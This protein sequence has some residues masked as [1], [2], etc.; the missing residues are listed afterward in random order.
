MSMNY[1]AIEDDGLV[2]SL[3]EDLDID[4]FVDYVKE[5]EGINLK[6]DLDDEDKDSLVN[7]IEEFLM[8]QIQY[9][10]TE[11]SFG[12][13]EIC[14]KRSYG[15]VVSACFDPIFAD[16]IDVDECSDD[17]IIMRLPRQASLFSAAYK[18][19]D[20]LIEEMKA[21]YGKFLK[22]DFDYRGRLAHLVGVEIG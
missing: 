22:K 18:D 14:C 11:L 16:Y 6:E 17:W 3:E 12:D 15:D 9:C 13:G 2:V 19:E 8:E 10:F 4:A 21:I 20:S 1:Y 5:H 7:A